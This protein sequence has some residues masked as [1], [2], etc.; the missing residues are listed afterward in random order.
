MHPGLATLNRLRLR[1]FVR[2]TLRR[3]TT[4]RGALLGVFVVVFF[5]FVIG[6]NVLMAFQ[7]PRAGPAS[8][9]AVAPLCILGLFLMTILTS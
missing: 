1:G 7:M 8:V 5:G 3:M 9:R 4:L 2:R 6:S